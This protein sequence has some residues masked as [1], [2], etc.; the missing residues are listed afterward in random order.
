MVNCQENDIEVDE[1]IKWDI[2]SN[3]DK[4]GISEVEVRVDLLN[5]YPRPLTNA[6]KENVKTAEE[7]EIMEKKF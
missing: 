1:G 2:L 6:E 7:K 3:S 4:D 5:K